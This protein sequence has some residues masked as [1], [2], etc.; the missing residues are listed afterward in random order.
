LLPSLNL[1]DIIYLAPDYYKDW[2][3]NIVK[4]IDKL[5]I[6]VLDKIIIISRR[7]N[8]ASMSASMTAPNQEVPHV[9][10]ANFDFMCPH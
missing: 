5:A 8:A 2:P 3:C 1:T 4:L 9:A 10:Q 7:V 6:P